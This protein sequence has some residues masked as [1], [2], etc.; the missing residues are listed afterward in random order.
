MYS[1]LGDGIVSLCPLAMEKSLP[2]KNNEAS[3]SGLTARFFDNSSA[4]M[5]EATFVGQPVIVLCPTNN[6]MGFNNEQCGLF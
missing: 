6:V 5:P 4:G 1:A 3:G 2:M